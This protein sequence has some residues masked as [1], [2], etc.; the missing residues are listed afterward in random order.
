MVGAAADADCV[1]YVDRFRSRAMGA[2]VFNRVVLMIDDN[3]DLPQ[4]GPTPQMRADSAREAVQIRNHVRR[5]RIERVGELLAKAKPEPWY[6]PTYFQ[7]RD[8]LD[9]VKELRDEIFEQ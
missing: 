2:S 4:M 8:L 6:P 9:A 7:F 1:W 5:K 3:N